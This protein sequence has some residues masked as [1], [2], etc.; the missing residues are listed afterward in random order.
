MQVLI[1]IAGFQNPETAHLL[2]GLGVWP[3]GDEHR[4]SEQIPQA[5]QKGICADASHSYWLSDEA[6]HK[7]K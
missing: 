7:L 1:Q 4:T 6:K 3:I 5:T 2:F